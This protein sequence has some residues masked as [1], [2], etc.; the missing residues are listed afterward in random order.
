MRPQLGKVRKQEESAKLSRVLQEQQEMLLERCPRKYRR[1]AKTQYTR[2]WPFQMNLLVEEAM[3]PVFPGKEVLC[4]KPLA[5]TRIVLLQQPVPWA[6]QDP[7]KE[8][9]LGQQGCQ[10]IQNG[11]VSHPGMVKMLS[12]SGDQEEQQ[13]LRAPIHHLLLPAE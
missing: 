9:C 5:I 6:P 7:A 11:G 3:Q 10:N 1:L 12:H 8:P 2:L 4:L 13:R